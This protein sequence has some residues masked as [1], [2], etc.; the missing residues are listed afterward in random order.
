MRAEDTGR[1]W[2]LEMGAE[3]GVATSEGRWQ[4]HRR[5]SMTL[6]MEPA[7]PAFG[8]SG[9]QSGESMRFCC[10]TAPSVWSPGNCTMASGCPVPRLLDASEI[11]PSPCWPCSKHMVR[12]HLE[13]LPL[14]PRGLTV[15]ALPIS[16]P[17]GKEAG[18]GLEGWEEGCHPNLASGT[19]RH[20]TGP[21]RKQEDSCPQQREGLNQR[22]GR[23]VSLLSRE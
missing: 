11:P 21:S 23:K 4:K 16:P 1:R 6:Q 5:C 3:T 17:G 8:S 19:S 10:L 13:R 15:R 22:R 18:P 2:P 20:C 9:L 14:R 7:R 12:S